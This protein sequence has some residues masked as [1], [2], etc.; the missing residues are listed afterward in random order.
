MAIRIEE[1][2]ELQA[3]CWNRPADAVLSLEDALATYESNW[4]H[5][6]QDRL[7]ARERALIDA[8][9]HD[10]GHGVFLS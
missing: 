5:V 10:V 7:T 4:R 9:I 3:I 2:S 6:R 8:L 1:Y